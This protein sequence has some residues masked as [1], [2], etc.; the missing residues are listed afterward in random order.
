MRV[1][2]EHKKQGSTQNGRPVKPSLYG[3][4][5]QCPGNSRVFD[6]IKSSGSPAVKEG[7]FACCARA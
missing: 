3:A 5:I 6:F 4:Q 1:Y 2:E 7:G